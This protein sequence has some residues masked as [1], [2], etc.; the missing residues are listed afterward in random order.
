MGMESMSEKE[1]EEIRKGGTWNPKNMTYNEKQDHDMYSGKTSIRTAQLA[2]DH[3]EMSPD[4]FEE[5]YDKINSDTENYY[6]R[7]K[8]TNNTHK[9]SSAHPFSR[10]ELM[11]R[12][13]KIKDLPGVSEEYDEYFEKHYAREAEKYN[14]KSKTMQSWWEKNTMWAMK[15][16]A[17]L[18]ALISVNGNDPQ[19]EVL[20]MRESFI[21]E[22]K[23]SGIEPQEAKAMMEQMLA[24]NQTTTEKDK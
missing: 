10:D 3:K 15:I 11:K 8:Q 16:A 20:K 14:R 19:T 2:R 22:C 7:L 13:P 12:D 24:Q 9:H 18:V 23:T 6:E 4:A 21:K 5:K 17:G 1:K